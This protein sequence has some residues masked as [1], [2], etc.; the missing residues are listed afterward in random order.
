MTIHALSDWFGV[1]GAGLGIGTVLGRFL[2]VRPLKA[3][4]ETMTHPIQP[5]ANGGKSL[6]DVATKLGVIE[7]KI[8]NLDSWLTKVDERFITHI[9]EHGSK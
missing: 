9:S 6:A 3:Y 7:T 8:D 5:D 2:I 1:I 4:I